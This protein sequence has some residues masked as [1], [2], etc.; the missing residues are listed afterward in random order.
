MKRQVKSYGL[1]GWRWYVLPA[2]ILVGTLTADAYI[3]IET[4]RND[5]EVARLKQRAQEIVEAREKFIG[6]GAASQQLHKLQ[7]KAMELGL[8][9]AEPWQVRTV[10]MAAPLASAESFVLA[11][12]DAKP[13]LAPEVPVVLASRPAPPSA[14]AP[15]VE[16]VL[17]PQPQPESLPAVPADPE[18]ATMD[19]LES[20]NG[21][22]AKLAPQPEE[23][24]A[25]VD[26]L[27]MDESPESMLAL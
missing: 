10:P 6:Q 22:V 7:E 11:M 18:L 8:R 20:F 2:G 14:P 26:V 15:L 27:S 4:R 1:N 9:A 23:D 19:L 25:E 24:P 5:Y 3:N 13:Q 16:A 21:H 12:P 17:M